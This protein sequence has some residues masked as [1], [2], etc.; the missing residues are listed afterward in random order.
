MFKKKYGKMTVGAWLN[1]EMEQT[2]PAIMLLGGGVMLLSGI[3]VRFF[4]GSPHMTLLALGMVDRIPPVWLLALLWSCSFFTVGCAAGFVLGYRNRG[5][6]VDK[7][8]GSMLFILAAVLELCWYPTFFCARL[9]FL[10]VLESILILCLCVG[11]T[12]CFY[13]VSKFAGVLLLFH[14]VWLIYM[15]FLNFSAFFRG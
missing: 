14:D 15:L 7:Y 6:D 3:F 9:V 5:C 4:S 10:S 8:K 11:A 13:R 2:R 1:M 12:L